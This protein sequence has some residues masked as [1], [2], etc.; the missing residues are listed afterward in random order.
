[1]KTHRCGTFASLIAVLAVFLFTIC[2]FVGVFWWNG[3]EYAHLSFPQKYYFLVRDCESAT[4]A[5]VAGQIYVSGGSGYYIESGELNAVV[6]SCYFR[7]EAAGLV[8]ES[9]KEKGVESR[10]VALAPKDLYLNGKIAVESTRISANAETAD[11]CARLLYDTANGLE[12]TEISQEEARAAVRGVQKSLQGLCLENRGDAY[13]RWNA[14]LTE[15]ER[16]CGEVADGILFSKDVRYILAQ[17][18]YAVV[19]LGNYFS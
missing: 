17:L 3:R 1:M 9:M 19:N 7:E 5:A 13:G 12:R 6:L 16:K 18:C 15:A 14:L 4:A 8:C 10:V 2:M 11:S